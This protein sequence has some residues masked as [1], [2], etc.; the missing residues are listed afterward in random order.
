[1][2]RYV[3]RVLSNAGRDALW[4]CLLA[5]C[6]ACKSQGA[7]P[8]TSVLSQPGPSLL[9]VAPIEDE[10]LY[11]AF[12]SSD[13]NVWLAN[14]K[15]STV[16]PLTRDGSQQ[17]PYAFSARGNPWHPEGGLLLVERSDVIYQLDIHRLTIT[18][19][20]QG[21][22]AVWSPDGARFA[23]V[24]G[25]RRF[26]VG[27]EPDPVLV[28]QRTNKMQ[29][30]FSTTGHIPCW[31]EGGSRLIYVTMLERGTYTTSMHSIRSWAVGATEPKVEF[32]LEA[33]PIVDMSLS[34][35][36]AHLAMRSTSI[37]YVPNLQVVNWKGWELWSSHGRVETSSNFGWSPTV[38]VLVALGYGAGIE[39][40]DARA[41]AESPMR[42]IGGW[43]LI[44]SPNGQYI[45]TTNGST[46][47]FRVMVGN[48]D[49]EL[50]GSSDYL[51]GDFIRAEPV[52]W[53]ADGSHL[54]FSLKD[55]V[56]VAEM[57]EQL[58]FHKI[59][60]GHSPRWRP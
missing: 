39:I 56:Y 32:P 14:I 49:A 20:G 27:L 2:N 45:A 8:S 21:H 3:L 47:R 26:W 9:A 59:A 40:F 36:G 6:V 29:P 58:Q 44:W 57:G 60:D 30:E 52:E 37:E 10:A 5:L 46:D 31:T 16:A 7:S 38:P 43:G 22:D 24:K 19:I 11:L 13:G 50:V 34:P 12:I 53:S 18:L 1:M 23:F 42:I 41:S 48:T 55:Q 35:Q 28:V 15:G 51:Q 54:A 17:E 25:L 4:M 33:D